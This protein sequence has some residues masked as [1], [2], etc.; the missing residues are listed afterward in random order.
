MTRQQIVDLAERA[1][2]TFVQAFLATF[3]LLISAAAPTSWSDLRSVAVAAATGAIAAG[4]SAVKVFLAQ[5][6]GN[7]TGATVPA[8]DEYASAA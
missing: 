8:R 3:V 1:L 7:G 4:L 5:R 2:W 6:F